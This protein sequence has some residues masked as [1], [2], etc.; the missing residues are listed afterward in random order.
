M[1]EGEP[2]TQRIR[3]AKAT[4]ELSRAAGVALVEMTAGLEQG[5]GIGEGADAATMALVAFAARARRLL[6]SAYRLID[7]AERDTAVPLFR[8]M[9][10]YL[11][12]GRWLLNQQ[13]EAFKTWALD[14]L[15][16]RLTIL[17]DVKA[18]LD[19]AEVELAALLETQITETE[20]ALRGYGG[21]EVKRTK[22]AARKAGEQPPP[23][24]EA[25]ATAVGLDFAYASS[26]RVQSQ[27]DVHASPLAID[28]AYDKVDDALV[29]RPIPHFADEHLDSYAFGAHLFL[30]I[31][32]P[33]AEKVPELD[34]SVTA[35][36][37]DET[38]RTVSQAVRVL[39]D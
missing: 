1:S 35:A 16:G 21:P 26:Y 34:W 29:V 27:A 17:R 15:R 11:I 13:E 6:R 30:D 36:M 31:I 14:D 10:E 25:M 23:T 4:R 20:D 22:S 7:A 24:L 18:E 33:L 2:Q 8:V 9:S 38:L 32:R 5:L 39:E 12:V 37:V 28:Y 3:N 19:D